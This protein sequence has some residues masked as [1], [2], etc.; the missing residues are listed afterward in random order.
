MR[1]FL[2][3]TLVVLAVGCSGSKWPPAKFV[4]ANSTHQLRINHQGT[5][6]AVTLLGIVGPIIT[7]NEYDATKH[8]L[9]SLTTRQGRLTRRSM[10]RIRSWCDN[11]KL[12]LIPPEDRLKDEQGRNVPL[13]VEVN[14]KDIAADLISEGL[15]RVCMDPNDPSKPLQH[16]R[17]EK[18]QKLQEDAKKRQVGCW[19][20]LPVSQKPILTPKARFV[21]LHSPTVLVVEVDG[22]QK[23]AQLLG[24]LPSPTWYNKPDDPGSGLLP[25]YQ[26]VQAELQATTIALCKDKELTLIHPE[27]RPWDAQGN[28]RPVYV[29]IGP[30]GPSDLGGFLISKGLLGT[31][32]M[33]GNHPLKDKYLKAQGAAQEQNI[34]MWSY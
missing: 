17:L 16:P 4:A 2:T 10:E 26:A 1:R 30:D 31:N 18:Y 7:G 20:P 27:G 12:L 19:Q 21:R 14:G 11:Q 34:G 3:G 23:A 33:A 13:Y 6:Q 28:L 25:A 5:Q 29:A 32:P 15:A 8:T 24:V 22:K 9:Q